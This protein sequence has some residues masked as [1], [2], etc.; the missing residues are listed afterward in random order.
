MQCFQWCLCYSFLMFIITWFL[1]GLSVYIKTYDTIYIGV[2]PGERYS[3]LFKNEVYESWFIQLPLKT[4][5]H[6]LHYL[7]YNIVNI[8]RNN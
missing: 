7:K 5:S 8:L 4:G 1:V 3:I 2:V 6:S